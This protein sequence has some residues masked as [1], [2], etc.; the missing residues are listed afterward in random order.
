MTKRNQVY[1]CEKCGNIVEMLNDAA[2]TLSCCGQEMTL[3]EEQ[4]ADKTLE[5]HVPIV[6][7]T[8]SGIKVTVGS[9]PHPMTEEHFIEWIEVIADGISYK[10][11]L[12][13]GME[14]SAEFEI[15]PDN[16]VVREHCNLH[17]LWKA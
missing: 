4:T 7:R 16:M 9:T 15:S 12:R 2:G 13:P 8:G 10:K 5:K 17:G 3:L 11:F 14:P 1:K 6:E